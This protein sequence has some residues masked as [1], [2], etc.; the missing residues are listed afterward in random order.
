MNPDESPPFITQQW[1]DD[2][3]GHIL[4]LC[5]S[6]TDRKPPMALVRCS[7]GGKTRALKELAKWL[8]EKRKDLSIIFVSA[9]DTTDLRDDEQSDPVGAICRRI[10]FAALKDPVKDF[11]SF[12]NTLVTQEQ[13]QKWIGDTPCVLLIDELNLV[14]ELLKTGSTLGHDLAVFLKKT[15][16][17]H[18]RHLVFTSHIVSVTSSLELYMEKVSEREV[19]I[20]RLPLATR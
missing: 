13:I 11:D 8:R 4:G 1:I 17:C 9:N 20:V 7:R 5:D 6:N 16:L 10:A 12:R 2:T 19:I 3:G 18:N 15:F 14:D